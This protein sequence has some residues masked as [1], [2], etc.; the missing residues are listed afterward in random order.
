M[1]SAKEFHDQCKV[2]LLGAA[3]SGKTTT[4]R[5]LID[6]EFLESSPTLGT[7]LSIYECRVKNEKIKLN[8]WDTAGQETY[9]KLA[10]IYYRDCNVALVFFDVT[11]KESYQDVKYWISELDSCGPPYYETIIV[12][13]KVDQEREVTSDQG[14]ELARRSKA[15]YMEISAKTG[16]NVKNLFNLVDQSFT[17]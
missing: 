4:L 12:A 15:C 14:S 16:Q 9:R 5:Q 7:N 11:S 10:K 6:G 8:I 13:N 2:V 1:I 17:R 3:N